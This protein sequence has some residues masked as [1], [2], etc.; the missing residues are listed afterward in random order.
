MEPKY[1]CQAGRAKPR[2]GLTWNREPQGGNAVEMEDKLAICRIVAQAILA[3]GAL[4]DEEHDL[5]TRLMD[6]FGL[7]D[8]QRKDVTGR[9]YGDDPLPLVR[10][11][12]EDAKQDVIN[13]LARVIAV[14]GEVAK[15]E[16]RVI[17]AVG[18]SLG[19]TSEQI[20]EAIAAAAS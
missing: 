8:E 1:P 16:R 19:I 10:D 4:T 13:E 15:T 17:G 6:G 5:L 14:D 9:N 3:D 18:A 11:V 20:D 7:T 12:S 2:I